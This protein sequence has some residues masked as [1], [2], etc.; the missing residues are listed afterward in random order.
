M[1]VEYNVMTDDK[2]ATE[3]KE[4]KAREGR[5]IEEEGLEEAR[6]R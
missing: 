1:D 2:V 5:R 4:K 6:M 3:N